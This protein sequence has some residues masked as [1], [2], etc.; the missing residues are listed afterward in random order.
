[1]R[2]LVVKGIFYIKRI[3]QENMK[4]IIFSWMIFSLLVLGTGL[5]IANGDDDYMHH[6]MMGGYYGGMFGFFGWICMLLVVVALV[7][8]IMWLIKQLQKD[9]TQKRRYKKR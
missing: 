3:F 9:D 5:V 4:K 6:G 2:N 1:M 8:L 7:L